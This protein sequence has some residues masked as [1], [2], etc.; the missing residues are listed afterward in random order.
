MGTTQTPLTKDGRIKVM[1]IVGNARLGG[2]VSCVL[3]Y[4]SHMDRSRYRFDF[5]TYGPSPLDEKLRSID[6]DSRVFTV[7]PFDGTSCLGAMRALKKILR[8]GGY[9]IVHSH[10]TTLSAFA[11]RAAKSA[12][13]PVRICHAH[14]TFD[15]QSDHYAVKAILRPFAARYATH[16]MACGSLAAQNLYRNHADDA[17]ILRNAIDLETFSYDAKAREKLGIRGR[18]L[19]FAGRFVPQKN[20]FFLLEAFALAQKKYPSQDLTL[21]L[22]GDGEQKRELAARAEALGL[23]ERVRLIGP[24]SLAPWYSAA[25]L[26]CLPSLYEGFPV[27]GIEAQA[28]GTPC[29]FSDKIAREADICKKSRFLPLDAEAW[30]D[31]M[32]QG[33]PR[34]A[35][36]H[37]TLQSAGYDIRRE[38]DGLAA[39]YDAALGQA[40]KH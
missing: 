5:V 39:F 27:V 17:F 25:D 31:A 29:L 23:G 32:A 3:N 40:A 13:I 19:L 15:R 35:H 12:G 1:Q 38:A 11:L 34:I 24:C 4:Y 33:L 22:V 20:L 9:A 21:A 36:P 7:P 26:F 2:V 30:A 18:L 14:S 10:L 6:P 16:R 8:E 28:C 37:E